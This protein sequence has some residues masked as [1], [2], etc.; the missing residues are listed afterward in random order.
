M[1]IP[2]FF[3]EHPLGKSFDIIKTWQNCGIFRPSLWSPESETC[4]VL[5]MNV[6]FVFCFVFASTVWEVSLFINFNLPT[7]PGRCNFSP[8]M[9]IQKSDVENFPPGVFESHDFYKPRNHPV[10]LA[11]MEIMPL[12]WCHFVHPCSI[13]NVWTLILPERT[14]NKRILSWE[15]N[16][17]DCGVGEPPSSSHD[18]FWKWVYFLLNS[19]KWFGHHEK[20][21]AM[22]NRNV[23]DSTPG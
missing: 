12:G 10:V 22:V 23:K 15:E 18:P 7:R 5:R 9:C 6:I 16:I 3:F 1:S 8:L 2:L 14:T 17:N 13:P 4:L 19:F 20:Y 21:Y 11:K